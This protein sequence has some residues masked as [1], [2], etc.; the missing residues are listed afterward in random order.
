MAT[1]PEDRPPVA[2][3]YHTEDLP[4]LPQR[5]YLIPAE[6]WVEAPRELRELGADF[7]VSLVA[8]KRRLGRFLLWRAG[9]ASRA[10]ACYMALAADDLDERYRFRLRPDGSGEGVGADGRTHER[11]R[12]WKEALLQRAT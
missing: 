6:R 10:D 9:P 3:D 4:A 5:D 8:Y 12:T 1:S 7:G 11:F 2:V